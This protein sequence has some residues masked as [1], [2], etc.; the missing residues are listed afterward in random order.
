MIECHDVSVCFISAHKTHSHTVEH[1][2]GLLAATGSLDSIFGRSHESKI[3]ELG[4]VF[5]KNKTLISH[6]GRLDPTD[7]C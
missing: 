3:P 2:I 5:K 6:G 7:K 1:Q 4:N